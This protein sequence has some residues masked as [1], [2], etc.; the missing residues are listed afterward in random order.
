MS[1]AK[2][3]ALETLEKVK[4]IYDEEGGDLLTGGFWANFMHEVN[5]QIK[6]INATT[7]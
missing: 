6:E 4:R 1:E 7:I 2:R 5:E 3:Q